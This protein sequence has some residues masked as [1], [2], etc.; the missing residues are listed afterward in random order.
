METAQSRT[1]AD[2]RAPGAAGGPPRRRIRALLGGATGSGKTEVALAWARLR[3]WEILSCDSG[4]A[5][6]GMGVGTAAPSAA[7]QASVVHHGVG[8]LPPVVPDS[9]A[10]FLR[11]TRDLLAT[12]GSDLLAVGGT[13]QYLSGLRDGLDPSPGTDPL[14]R[15]S[16]EERLRCEGP[17][18]LFA[19]LSARQV[20]PHDARANPVRLVRALE[21]CILRDRGEVGEGFEALAPGVPAFALCWPRDVLHARLERRLDAM[22][23]AGWVQ[24]VAA[25]KAAGIGPEAPGL[26]A[27][28]YR[29]LGGIPAAAPVPGEVRE[30]ILVATRAYARRQETWLRNRLRARFIAPLDTAAAT[31]ALLDSLLEPQA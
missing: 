10:D 27:I 9:V 19:E 24:E 13:G 22:L 12:P 31:A 14:V 17:E 29:E 16:L 30:A 26:R 2:D 23:S 21:K 3:G 7:E 11:R 28:G 20:P 8:V 15:A 18:V 1:R 4:Q 5:R 25:L 6:V